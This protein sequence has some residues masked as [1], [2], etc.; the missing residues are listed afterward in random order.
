[1]KSVISTTTPMAMARS[2]D[3]RRDPPATHA[4]YDVEEDMAAVEGQEGQQID[5]AQVDRQEGE[6][7]RVPALAH[8]GLRDREDADRAGRAVGTGGLI[9]PLKSM[10]K[11]LKVAVT[12]PQVCE[13]ARP[14]ARHGV[15]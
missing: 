7:D 13:A 10:P 9:L 8:R 14:A 6:E 5:D 2:K 4:L 12:M 1:M 3:A 11:P 15:G